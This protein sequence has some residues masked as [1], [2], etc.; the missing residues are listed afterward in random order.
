M[1]CW[2]IQL[3]DQQGL[4]WI[5]F[6][7]SGAVFRRVSCLQGNLA[8]IAH[9]LCGH[10]LWAM[11]ALE[12]L[13]LDVES[14]CHPSHLWWNPVWSE[15]CSYK[16]TTAWSVDCQSVVGQIPSRWTLPHHYK[17]HLTARRHFGGIASQKWKREVNLVIWKWQMANSQVMIKQNLIY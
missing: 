5:A 14:S 2:S 11:A 7:S 4:S 1:S 13:L 16:P 6:W 9:S 10:I 12:W 15:Q 3:P 17:V 8:P